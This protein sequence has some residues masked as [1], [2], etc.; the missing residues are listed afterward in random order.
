MMQ[1]PECEVYPN[2]KST[3]KKGYPNEGPPERKSLPKLKVDRN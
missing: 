2:E 1:S 3:P